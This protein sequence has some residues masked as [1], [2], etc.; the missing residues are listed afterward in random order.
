MMK[1]IH[2]M[3]TAIFFLA[4]S[5]S[6][7]A[8]FNLNQVPAQ[9]LSN[10]DPTVLKAAISGHSNNGN[11]TDPAWIITGVDKFTDVNTSSPT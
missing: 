6:M 4:V 3:I 1:T 11:T 9:N 7:I 10:P 5:V 2:N 8:V